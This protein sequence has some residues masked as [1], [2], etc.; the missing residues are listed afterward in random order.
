M[1]E[2]EF[3]NVRVDPA[4]RQMGQR[5]NFDP[6][7]LDTVDAISSTANVNGFVPLTAIANN[8]NW[9][10]EMINNFVKSVNQNNEVGINNQL[11]PTLLLV[12]S[13]DRKRDQQYLINDFFNAC[14]HLKI[15]TLRFTH[16]GYILNR[17]PE[18]QITNILQYIMDNEE[19]LTL[20]RIY[21]DVDE[22]H[23]QNILGL[24]NRLRN[25]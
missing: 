13:F 8:M 25:N 1:P 18:E 16:F 7:H 19:T 6:S 9:P 23:M 5:W 17:F 3:L 24:Y 14:N 2:I 11:N 15:K 10:A 21:W 4:E 20:D 12:P 22:N